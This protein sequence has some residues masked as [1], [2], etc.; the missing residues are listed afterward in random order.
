MAF[1]IYKKGQGKYTR[2]CTAF[3]AAIIA[4]LG[5]MELYKSIPPDL[6]GMWVQTMVPVGIFVILGL[7]IF[8]L[9]NKP[10]VA[11][12][13]ISA[14]GEMKKVSWSSKSE[15]AFSTLVVI[16][17]VILLAV[18]LG[19]VDLGFELFFSDVVGI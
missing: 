1:E 6:G 15:V 11:N 2:L 19:A 7:L 13:M 12:F 5:C 10:S 9:V 14:E 3:G 4:A 17:V 16:A 18:F 8:Y